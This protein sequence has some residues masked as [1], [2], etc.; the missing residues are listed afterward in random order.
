M[1]TRR[2]NR[3]TLIERFIMSSQFFGLYIAQSG[4]NAFQ[5]SINTTANNISNVETEGYSRQEVVLKAS[6]S[7]RAFQKYGSVSTG[8]DPQ[9]VSQ[10]RDKYYDD[11]YWINQSSYGYYDTKLYYMNQIEDYYTDS[12]ATQGFTTI[13]SSMFNSLDAIK[14]SPSDN[15]VRAQFVNDAEKLARYFNNTSTKLS[16]LQMSI[17]D[18]I[19]AQVDDINSI[20]SKI[21]TLNKQINTL[22]V[23]GSNA[24]ELRDERALLLDKLSE[25]VAIETQEEKVIDPNFPDLETGL[26][27][28]NVKING[29]SLVDTDKYYKL[30]VETRDSVD[31]L[32][33][34]AGLYE[35]KWENTGMRLNITG[36][37]Q[38][39]RLRSLV[40]IR[41]GNDS[42]NIH[43]TVSSQA[44]DNPDYKTD[45]K[46]IVIENTNYTDLNKINFPP[47]GDVTIKGIN[48]KYDSFDVQLDDEGKISAI[49]F[50]LTG[51]LTVDQQVNIKGAQ[52]SVGNTIDCKG[53][54]YYQNEMNTFLRALSEAFNDIEKEGEDLYGNMGQAFFVGID[55]ITSEEH[56]FDDLIYDKNSGKTNFS[57]EDDTYFKLTAGSI[58][59]NSDIHNDL[60]L[61]ATAEYK[62]DEQGVDDSTLVD[63]LKLLQ[64]DVVLYRSGGASAFLETIYSDV[65]VDT[66]EATMFQ[67]YYTNIQKSIDKQRK[68][69]SGVDEDEEAQNLVKFQNAYNLS[70]KVISVLAEMYDQL[71]LN[72]GL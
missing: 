31:N 70:S 71:I 68:S 22:E 34:V 53:I 26:T 13:F 36:Y 57:S 4:L 19:K 11:K 51:A 6:S 42:S 29:Q 56:K 52:A 48:Y 10:L 64:D 25:I 61:F 49:R 8:V 39:G 2:S 32:M 55:T 7:L 37:N 9:A 46:H 17:N 30:T 20:A 12:N 62:P 60:R 28:F 41:D 58:W 59:I 35:V 21:T 1:M 14:S 47:A 33:D 44:A 72:T 67:E 23:S 3:L 27:R 18:E 15:T 63:R 24:N 54:P 50:N 43:G 40:E 5:A 45:N 69:V 65:T 16:Q 38:T 66:R